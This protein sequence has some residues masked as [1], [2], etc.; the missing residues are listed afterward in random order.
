M[1]KTVNIKVEKELWVK[2]QDDAFKKL[3]KKAKIDGFRPG[4]APRS[5]FEKNYGKTDI[6]YEAANQ[7]INDK[8]EEAL[9]EAAMVPEMEPK[10]DIVKCDEESLEVTYTFIAVSEVKLGEYKNLGIKKETAKVTKKEVEHEISHILDS[11]AEIA[12]KDGKVEN[13]DIA[14]IDFEGFKDG[15]PFA[16]GKSENYELEIGSNSFIPGFEEGLIGMEKGEE[17]DLE[18]TFPKDYHSEELKGKK[19]VFKVKVNEVK[20]RIVPEMNEEFF[21]DL[22]MPG[23]ASKEDLEK[24]VEMH[25]KEHKQHHIDEEYTFKVLDKAVENMTIDIEEE[26]LDIEAEATYED[27]TNKLASQG[28]NEEL[29]FS[30]ANTD[31]EKLLEQMKKEADKKIKYRYLLNEVVKQEEIKVTDEDAEAKINELIE[32]YNITKEDVLKEFGSIEAIKY[33]IMINKAVEVMMSN[34]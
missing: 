25:M 29:Y 24:E 23:V 19:V 31:R 34:K 12:E 22:A 9:K 7:M 11:Y 32:K 17:K 27:F 15:E 10:I 5:V 33:E 2:A 18:L 1:K 20:E 3:N 14:I 4:K 6:I 30:Y 28:L 8:Y 13:G 16:G 26:M 21:E